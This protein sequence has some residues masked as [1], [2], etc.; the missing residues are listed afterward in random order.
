MGKLYELLAVEDTTNKQANKMF[1]DTEVKFSN[2]SRYLTGSLRTLS[3]LGDTEQDKRTEEAARS[4][5][6]LP[7]TVVKTLEYAL[8]K[9]MNSM[10]VKLQKHMTN[11]KAKAD[12]EVEGMPVLKDIPVDFLLDLEK[13]IPHLR[14]LFETMPT[15]D[16]SRKWQQESDGVWKAVDSVVTVQTEKVTQPVVLY[17]ATKEH[18]AQVKESTKDVVVGNFTQVDFSGAA[19]AQQ[20]ADVIAFLDDF[21]K[22]VKAARMRANAV[23]VENT[24]NVIKEITHAIM[25]NFE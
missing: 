16:P 7:T 14:K 23:E 15:L 24:G 4:V 9:I 21:L 3:R 20:K 1:T 6:E 10:N 5:K 12:V 17:E 22:A 18:P 19:T 11:T 25:S 2:H 13:V 8:P